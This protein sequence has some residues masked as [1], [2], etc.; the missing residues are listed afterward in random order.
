MTLIPP[1]EPASDAAHRATTSVT[2]PATTSPTSS[3]TAIAPPDGAVRLTHWGLIEASGEEAASF[4]HNQLSQDVQHLGDG[5]ARL[6]AYCSAKGRM[7]AS[8]LLLRPAAD[9]IWLACSAEVLPAT[10]KRLRMFVLRAK[11]RLEDASGALAI[12]GLA[13]PSARKWLGEAAP[14]SPWQVT[15][16]GAALIAA[17]PPGAAP[18]WLWIGPASEADEVLAALP[19]LPA[20]DW[21]WLEVQTG[22]PMIEAAT[23]EQFVPQMVNLDLVGG[24]NFKKG[25]YP[26]QEIVAR[27]QYLGKL[28]RRMVHAEADGLLAAGQEVFA[29]SD[30]GQPAGMV[31]NAAPAPG[32]GCSALVEVKLAAWSQGG[33]HAGS[34]DGPLLRPASLPY[35]VPELQEPAAAGDTAPAAS[36]AS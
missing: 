19:A 14:Q 9:R 27:T 1:S 22:V 7:L 30:P 16:R 26:G 24:V 28:K 23:V 4:L 29:A 35:A 13:G 18:G 21:R 10:L 32:G 33:L 17:L 5:E 31:V 2:T 15:R 11:A 25:C 6:A 36:S 3:A 20:P 34:P 8:V 12:L